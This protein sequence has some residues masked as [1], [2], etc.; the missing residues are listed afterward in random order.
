MS[1]SKRI[2]PFDLEGV[3]QIPD[4]EEASKVIVL[5]TALGEYLIT[6]PKKL[7]SSVDVLALAGQPVRV[8]GKKTLHLKKGW[9][10]LKANAI[11]PLSSAPTPPEPELGTQ[12]PE[13]ERSED[14][15]PKKKKSRKGKDTAFVVGDRP[16]SPQPAAKSASPSKKSQAQI[17]VCKKSD[18]CKKGGIDV[19][20]AL[21]TELN[22]RQL[23]H[24][25]NVKPT[26]CMKRCKAGPNL[27]MPD[28]TRHTRV[29]AKDVPLLVEQHVSALVNE[30]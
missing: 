17:L 19:I 18:C 5:S 27:V 29:K 22:D 4:Q 3:C 12:T 28:K 13:R 1:S 14:D 23:G 9:M 20:K 7:R 2:L 30:S 25:V 8:R 10:T 6:L 11:A 15:T 26:G 21:R 24:Q 16:S